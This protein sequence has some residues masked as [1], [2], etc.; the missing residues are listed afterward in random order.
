MT[1]PQKD[2]RMREAEEISLKHRL[3][4]FDE[5]TNRAPR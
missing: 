3:T 5:M 2:F 4:K 1:I